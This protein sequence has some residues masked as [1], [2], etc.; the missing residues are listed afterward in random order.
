MT[1]HDYRHIEG[2]EDQFLYLDITDLTGRQYVERREQRRL[3]LE[4][5]YGFPVKVFGERTNVYHGTVVMM[6]VMFTRKGRKLV[7]LH[8]RDDGEVDCE[9]E[10]PPSLAK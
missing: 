5:K 8:F 3:E 6:R 2:D 9:F 4:A 1:K 7:G 10:E